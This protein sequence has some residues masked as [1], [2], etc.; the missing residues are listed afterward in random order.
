MRREELRG[1][2]NASEVERA[3]S[4]T[5]STPTQ[6]QLDGRTVLRISNHRL[7]RWGIAGI[8]CD[9]RGTCVIPRREH[10]RYNCSGYSATSLTPTALAPSRF[11]D[12]LVVGQKISS[13]VV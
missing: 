9:V 4:L 13:C 6:T 5:T 11:N 3:S 1:S 7:G 12:T 10:F 2:A 8:Q